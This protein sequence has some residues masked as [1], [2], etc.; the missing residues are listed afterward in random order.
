[1]L[2]ARDG[3]A[4]FVMQIAPADQN[5]GRWEQLPPLT[6]GNLLAPRNNSLAQVLAASPDGAP[7]LI[8]LDT[9]RNR[10]LAFAGDTTWQWAMLGFAEDHLRFW[11]Q[12]IFWL[13]RKETD[14]SQ[15][16]WIQAEPRDLTPGAPATLTVGARDA[17]GLPVSDAEFAIEITDPKG[18]LLPLTPRREIAASTAEFT[19]TLEPGDY[20]ARVRASRAGQPFGNIGVTRF[21]VVPNDPERDNPA[22]E[23]DVLRRIAENSGG[24]FLTQEQFIEKLQTWAED[25]LPGMNLKRQERISLWDTPPVLLLLIALLTVE[26]GIRRRSQL[27]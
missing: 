4:H 26:W 14:D 9:G 23:F 27:M 21:H 22:A 17:Q 15:A 12:V 25:G 18:K 6:G 11:R 16:V 1:M 7:L 20:W 19:E 24:Q 2:P 3:L 10:S 13:T 5:R 8:G